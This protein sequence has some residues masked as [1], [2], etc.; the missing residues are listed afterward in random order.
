MCL[1]RRIAFSVVDYR[2]GGKL[3]RSELLDLRLQAM[4]SCNVFVCLQDTYDQ[5]MDVL[6]ISQADWNIMCEAAA[7]KA[8]WA[9]HGLDPVHVEVTAA[10]LSNQPLIPRDRCFFG[11]PN[12]YARAAVVARPHQ[13][14]S[15]LDGVSRAP[16]PSISA[17]VDGH[18]SGW[19]LIDQV[20]SLGAPVIEF[21]SPAN[22]FAVLRKKIA[23]RVRSMYPMLSVSPAR[24][25]L[26]NTRLMMEGVAEARGRGVVDRWDVIQKID[27]FVQKGYHAAQTS[28]QST[29][30]TSEGRITGHH[31]AAAEGSRSLSSPLVLIS[32][33]GMGK[34][35]SL[36]NWMRVYRSSH[37]GHRVIYH[38]MLPSPQCSSTLS[39]IMR[40]SME[41]SPWIDESCVSDAHSV[42]A[43]FS[44]ALL[45]ANESAAHTGSLVIIILD[46][47]NHTHDL[48]WAPTFLPPAIRLIVS[49]TSQSSFDSKSDAASVSSKR[50]IS[51]EGKRSINVVSRLTLPRHCFLLLSSQSHVHNKAWS[52]ATACST[53][54]NACCWTRGKLYFCRVVA[55][56]AAV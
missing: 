44:T 33:S 6:G 45:W 39:I 42:K 46:A 38:S 8:P 13:Q 56:S 31:E 17:A 30:G 26:W 29:H 34:T 3:Q 55:R 11:W 50:A 35:S 21:S 32:E 20:T 27:D 15:A 2:T 4:K 7:V 22:L 18:P 14:N 48:S 51:K 49:A 10:A 37:P 36:I 28:L 53:C 41:L 12:S 9:K 47:V 5:E 40:L 23:G 52:M 1:R 16:G 54:L 19:V 43:L 24:Q 25:W